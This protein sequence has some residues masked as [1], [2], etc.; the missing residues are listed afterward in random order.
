M[1]QKVVA[2]IFETQDYGIFKSLEGNRTDA[3][4]R[5][6]KVIDSINTVGYIRSP[7]AVNEKMEVIDG[8][9][10]LVA[11][12]KLGMPVHYHIIPG[13]G[14]DECVA[15][16]IYG[17]KWKV[18]DYIGS[19]ATR[20]FAD[21]VRLQKL[22]DDYG[23]FKKSPSIAI[24]AASDIDA[25]NVQDVIIKG[26]F[27]FT[28]EKDA[29]AREALSILQKVWPSIRKINGRKDHFA[30]AILWLVMDYEGELDVE[31]LINRIELSYADI[32]PVASIDSA[33][34]GLSKIYNVRN[35]AEKKYFDVDYDKY[36]RK[37]YVWYANRKDGKGW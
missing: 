19:Y 21:Y 26:K 12:K 18:T 23:E 35:R 22:I 28:E 10:R 25:K 8:Q 6:A 16:N 4:A 29:A 3:E 15:M 5:A 27:K 36:L 20:G 37:K 32:P 11:L 30:F 34:K 9:A 24:R 17:T 33:L 1:K 13:A 7:M 14:I 31:K 2:E